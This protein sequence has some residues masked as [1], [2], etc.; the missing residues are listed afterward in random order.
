MRL[1][2]LTP[3]MAPTVYL[4]C[5]TIARP[6]GGKAQSP[7]SGRCSDSTSRRPKGIRA[8]FPN[9]T[10]CANPYTRWHLQ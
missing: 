9:T 8:Y 7:V 6:N 5:F 2:T 3:T 4:H 1:H 10:T